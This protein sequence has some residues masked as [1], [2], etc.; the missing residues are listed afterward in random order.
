[1]NCVQG[2]DASGL[3][4]IDSAAVTSCG[5]RIVSRFTH[6]PY[7]DLV[8]LTLRA[9]SDVVHVT[10]LTHLQTTTSDTTLAVLSDRT[11]SHIWLLV[12]A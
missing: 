4:F 12:P 3:L 6:S 7:L 8:Y 2:N 5:F 11:V 10:G 1:M 9:M